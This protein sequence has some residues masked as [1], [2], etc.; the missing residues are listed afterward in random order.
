[1]SLPS[2]TPL[3]VNKLLIKKVPIHKKPNF[4]LAFYLPV[5]RENAYV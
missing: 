5:L 4:L 2:D 1:M 3:S